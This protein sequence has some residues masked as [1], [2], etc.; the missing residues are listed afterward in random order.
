MGRDALPLSGEAL[1]SDKARP[2]DFKNCSLFGR[3]VK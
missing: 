2:T 1:E 3:I